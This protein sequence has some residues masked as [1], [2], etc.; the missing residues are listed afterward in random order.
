MSDSPFAVEM[1][2]ITIR[3]PGVLANDHVN[4]ALKRGEIHALLGENGAG[5]STLMNVL[6]GLY[7]PTAGII[8]V[9][10]QV[11]QFHSPRD[12][13]SKGIGRF[14]S[15]S[16]WCQPRPSPRMFCWGSLQRP[17]S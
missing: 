14:T 11:V 16:C 12:A 13:I 9:D 7:K 10:D 17:A 4:F 8:K 5:K 15:I 6:S 1:Q 2:D 3:F